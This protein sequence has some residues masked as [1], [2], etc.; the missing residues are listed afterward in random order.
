MTAKTPAPSQLIAAIRAAQPA[1]VLAAL[2]AGADV[3][4]T[5]MHGFAGLP[6]RTACF[7]GD[8]SIV[9]ELLRHGAHPDVAASDGPAAALRL[10][11]RCGHRD[12]AG[13]LLQYGAS[14]PAGLAVD[15]QLIPTHRAPEQNT[16]PTAKP[17]D[18]L[19]E[20]TPSGFNYRAANDSETLDIFGTETKALSADLLFLEDNEIPPIDWTAHPEPK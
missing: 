18:N 2:A 5:D 6:L 4:E 8:L 11:L 20:F 9:D 7:M 12:I 13:L 15:P 10:A 16:P 14:I 19:I 1:K 17:A 3:N